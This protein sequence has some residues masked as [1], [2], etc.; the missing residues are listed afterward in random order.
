MTADGRQTMDEDGATQAQGDPGEESLLKQFFPVRE[1]PTSLRARITRTYA[2]LLVGP[3]LGAG[4]AVTT[5]AVIAASATT[6]SALMVIFVV[7]FILLLCGWGL[8]MWHTPRLGLGE[9]TVWCAA[10]LPLLV[11]VAGAALRS[12]PAVIALVACAPLVVALL[13]GRRWVAAALAGAATIVLVTTAALGAFTIDE[14]EAEDRVVE[15]LRS[16]GVGAFGLPFDS[17][18]RPTDVQVSDDS[19][20]YEVEADYLTHSVTITRQDAGDDPAAGGEARNTS[21][22]EAVRYARGMVITVGTRTGIGDRD[23]A[24]A[25]DFADRLEWKSPEAFARAAD[26]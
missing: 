5:A 18:Y 17:T 26:L 10:L 21:R 9:F 6:W 8:G 11:V 3:L 25:V 14:G 20:T 1:A 15:D 2:G 16:S 7:G 19:L 24:A 22:G 23:P 13:A 12:W 4:V